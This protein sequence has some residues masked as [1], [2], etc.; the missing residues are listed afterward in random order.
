MIDHGVNI[1]LIL[2]GKKKSTQY[3][4]DSDNPSVVPM[5]ISYPNA[6]SY[7]E[8]EEDLEDENFSR[9]AITVKLPKSQIQKEAESSTNDVK[10]ARHVLETSRL[11]NSSSQWLHFSGSKSF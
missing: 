1:Y 8:E 4:D 5:S 11:K 7:H 2:F 9:F 10:L 3:E 6:L